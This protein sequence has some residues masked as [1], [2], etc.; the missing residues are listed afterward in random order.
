MK[1]FRVLEVSM[2]RNSFGLRGVILVARDGEARE[3]AS[4]DVNLPIKGRDY[5][6]FIPANPLEPEAHYVTGTF[7]GYGWALPRRLP[8]APAE[9]VA[10]AFADH[11]LEAR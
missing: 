1:T 2:N 7:S 10:L 4:N 3:I 5:T 9:A 8:T 6:V 11:A